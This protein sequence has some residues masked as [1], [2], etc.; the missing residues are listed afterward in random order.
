[1][2]KFLPLAVVATT[3]AL[4]YPASTFAQA[5]NTATKTDKG[6]LTIR[7]CLNILAGLYQ[8]DAGKVVDGK[9]LG[10]FKL[11]SNVKDALSHNIF[12]LGQVQ[13]EAQTAD[14]RIQAE[15]RGEANGDLNQR[16]LLALDQRR[17]DYFDRP[18]TAELDRIKRSDLDLDK[19]DIPASAV[20]NL[21]PILEH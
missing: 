12:V 16:Q 13:L 5:P 7:A 18:C 11:P 10:Q 6:G 17:N 19:N 9:S 3:L 1:M 2:S 4:A 14:R 21:W 20:G 15:I 8:I